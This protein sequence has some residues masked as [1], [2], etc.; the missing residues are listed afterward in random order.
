LDAEINQN[1]LM[2]SLLHLSNID[3]NR[4]TVEPP[5]GAE[6]KKYM[7]K[8][9][10]E[11]I[12]TYGEEGRAFVEKSRVS[13]IDVTTMPIPGR[14]TTFDDYVTQRVLNFGAG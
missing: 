12:E 5:K 11:V 10:L 1:N 9:L 7:A 4:T 14:A 3:T 6:I 2:S 8:K 13:W